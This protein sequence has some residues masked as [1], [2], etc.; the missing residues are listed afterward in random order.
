MTVS[1][2]RCLSR[3]T[4]ALYIASPECWC[5]MVQVSPL[6]ADAREKGC[7]RSRQPARYSRQASDALDPADRLETCATL[8]RLG[9][10]APS[11]A[12]TNPVTTGSRCWCTAQGR[13][14]DGS[15]GVPAAGRSVNEHD[16][17]HLSVCSSLLQ[18][19]LSTGLARP[20]SCARSK[21]ASLG[22]CTSGLVGSFASSGIGGW[23]TC[24]RRDVAC[25]CMR[26]RPSEHPER[27]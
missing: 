20:L 19:L 24:G 16:C 3:C 17:R 26:V 27:R 7:P 9:P 13:V 25:A 21:R 2:H 1:I 18:A 4:H 5:I 11:E 10:A 22:T 6:R 14:F 23:R 15:R 12:S 8:A